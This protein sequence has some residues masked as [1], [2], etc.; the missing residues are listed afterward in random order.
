[1]A[2]HLVCPPE[3]GGASGPKWK[4][5]RWLEVSEDMDGSVSPV[6]TVRDLIR[7][8]CFHDTCDLS[9]AR[10]YV[11]TLRSLGDVQGGSD[12]G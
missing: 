2:R 10:K 4:V 9:C 7:K 5:L 1:M 11:A 12:H 3:I 6:V 8:E